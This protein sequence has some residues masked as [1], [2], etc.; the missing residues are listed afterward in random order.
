VKLFRKISIIAP[1][2]IMFNNIKK[3]VS[4]AFMLN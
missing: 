4:G 1:T 3:D 2:K